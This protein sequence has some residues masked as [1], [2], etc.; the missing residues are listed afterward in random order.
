MW[1]V[2]GQILPTC[3]FYYI[4]FLFDS[5]FKFNTY[6]VNTLYRQISI[7]FIGLKSDNFSGCWTLIPS[8]H[9]KNNESPLPPKKIKI[10]VYAAVILCKI[11]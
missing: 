6:I 9:L 4:I 5:L 1:A 11:L 3:P 2:G 7:I 8:A 10:P